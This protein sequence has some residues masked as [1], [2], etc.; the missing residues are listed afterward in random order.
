[1]S[2]KMSNSWTFWYHTH[3][4]KDWSRESYKI[5]HKVKT[6]E[7]LWG[8]FKLITP[9]H[10][11]N[12]MFFIMKDDIFPDWKSPENENGGFW[13]IKIDTRT[14][15]NILNILKIWVNYL[16]TGRIVSKNSCIIVHGISIS[17]KNSHCVL[18]VWIRDKKF[19]KFNNML[20][21]ELPYVKTCK[22]TSFSNK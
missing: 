15:N 8:V 21:N 1:M 3:D 6:A 14:D 7:E 20:S 11:E 17:P 2:T 18:K 10:F 5:I 4:T 16:V 22:F 9:Q 13:S 19:V 12:G